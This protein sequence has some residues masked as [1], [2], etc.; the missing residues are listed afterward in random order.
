[1]LF[2]FV[3]SCMHFLIMNQ[4]Q[5]DHQ[6]GSTPFAPPAL[7]QIQRKLIAALILAFIFMIVEVVGGEEG[8]FQQP[9]CGAGKQ[10][11]RGCG[12]AARPGACKRMPPHLRWYAVMLL[13]PLP[14]VAL[15][16][17]IMAHSLAIITDAAHLVRAGQPA[18]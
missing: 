7:L 10:P 4:A 18:L 8:V 1:M 16:A 13:W 11:G 9:A 15:V 3:P 12:P 6:L 5:F 14:I 2:D 17:G